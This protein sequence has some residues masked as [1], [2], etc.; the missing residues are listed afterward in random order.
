MRYREDLE[1]F[2][3]V[4]G[5]VQGIPLKALL[6]LQR[7]KQTSWNQNKLPT[8]KESEVDECIM[9][10]MARTTWLSKEEEKF[11]AADFDKSSQNKFKSSM[12]LVNLLALNE[13]FPFN[14][15]SSTFIVIYKIWCILT[16]SPHQTSN[17]LT[18]QSL[19]VSLLLYQGFSS[20]GLPERPRAFQK[21][22][23]KGRWITFSTAHGG[24]WCHHQEILWVLSHIPVPRVQDYLHSQEIF[25]GWC[26]PGERQ[27]NG[28]TF[29]WAVMQERLLTF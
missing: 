23:R 24:C 28:S 4:T 5:F 22:C 8:G 7:S 14:S 1:F 29:C 20:P 10:Y 6:L 2:H 26:F 16:L 21:R 3:I 25:S 11:T 13:T 9:K 27:K 12:S 19:F 17:P 15:F 18:L